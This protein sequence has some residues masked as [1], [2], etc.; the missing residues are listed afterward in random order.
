MG[1]S[2]EAGIPYR[3]AMLIAALLLA[4]TAPQTC[5]AMDVNLPAPLANWTAPREDLIVGS[6]VVLPNRDGRADT[7]FEVTT[8]GRYGVALDQGGWIDVIPAETGKRPIESAAPALKSVAHGH[9]PECSTIRKIVRFDL[10]PGVYR[11][12][13][14][15]LSKP[16]AKLML[17]GP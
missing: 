16:N 12:S 11:V 10:T 7:V 4:Q 9:G 8:A 2:C 17:V 15:K 6:T 14:A 13:L 5:A 3:R 1:I